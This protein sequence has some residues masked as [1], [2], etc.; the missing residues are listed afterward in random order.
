LRH[1]ATTFAADGG[2]AGVGRYGS[3]SKPKPIEI[4]MAAKRPD[5]D[6]L[7]LIENDFMSRMGGRHDHAHPLEA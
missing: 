1:A 5:L 7:A 4:I 3:E 2:S 6:R